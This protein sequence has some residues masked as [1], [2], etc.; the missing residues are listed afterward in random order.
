MA[1][2]VRG[3]DVLAEM[4]SVVGGG[5]D[6]GQSV[7]LVTHGDIVAQWVEITTQE[8]VMEC[9]YCGWVVSKAPSGEAVAAPLGYERVAVEGVMSMNLMG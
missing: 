4:A 5:N 3:R 2:R 9:G 1:W 8:T 6:K 7:L